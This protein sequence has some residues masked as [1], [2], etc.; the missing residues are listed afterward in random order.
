M[1]TPVVDVLFSYAKHPRTDL[2]VIREAI[3]PEALLII[4]SGAYAAWS[5]GKPIAL[6]DYAEFL[7]RWDGV[8]SMAITL[9]VIGDGEATKTN[10]AT[11]HDLGFPVVPVYTVGAPLTD[12]DDYVADT[13]CLALGGLTTQPRSP[14]TD[15]YRRLLCDRSRAGGAVVHLLG[16][17]KPQT[18]RDGR[19]FSCDVSTASR[20]LNRG[21][22][23]LW[24]G[25]S[26]T[27]VGLAHRDSLR[28][29]RD[30]L[31]G[32]GLDLRRC[33]DGR[34]LA[35][36]DYKKDLIEASMFSYVAYGASVRSSVDPVP[37]PAAVTTGRTGPRVVVAVDARV[38]V[39]GRVASRLA[40]G[41]VP[42][43]L[44]RHLVGTDEA[45]AA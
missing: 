23:S 3:G 24:N 16:V 17:S 11:L 4:D 33:L 10:T 12:L 32:Y 15:R 13:D 44:R 42:P 26:L 6:T 1:L 7:R 20:S 37:V 41:D 22:L 27:Y 21:N 18:L 34:A 25:H 31:A 19:P 36:P 30:L 9:D 14:V 39:I 29:H 40:T 5:S 43:L 2:G 38:D 28:K 45:V 35:V 8:Y